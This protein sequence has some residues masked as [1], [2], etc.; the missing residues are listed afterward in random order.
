MGRSGRSWDG[1][2][3]RVNKAPSRTPPPQHPW[4][5]LVVLFH[6]SCNTEC[7]RVD[8]GESSFLVRY[9][10]LEAEC[11]PDRVTIAASP[12]CSV[13][14]CTSSIA[15]GMAHFSLKNVVLTFS[16]KYEVIYAYCRKLGKY[17]DVWMIKQRSSVLLPPSNNHFDILELLVTRFYLHMWIDNVTCTPGVPR[18]HQLGV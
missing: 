1:S 3:V 10:F 16:S 7:R 4:D 18:P 5:E 8:S 15:R 14:R 9:C 6:T 13:A 2:E 11:A 12:L 17:G